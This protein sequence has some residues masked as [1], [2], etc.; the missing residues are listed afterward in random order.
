[1]R[2]L[3]KNA[4]SKIELNKC[5]K[6]VI[7]NTLEQKIEEKNIDKN[8]LLRWCACAAVL[9]FAILIIPQT[10]GHVYAAVEYVKEM[11]VFADGNTVE[12]IKEEN[13]TSASVEI[14]SES[15]IR[16]QDE[17]LYFVLDDICIDITDKVSGE[18]WFRYEHILEDGN[19]SV[20]LIG[21]SAPDYGWVELLFDNKGNYITN[22]MHVPNEKEAWLEQSM[23]EEG[24]PTGNPELDMKLK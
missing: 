3:Y 4:F 15:Y 19:R 20:I 11:F 6:M 17:T 18:S 8:P 24:V 14:T 13:E 16:V 21:G 7:W 5:E 10:R 9:V 22:R 23:H 1:M 12:I 2:T